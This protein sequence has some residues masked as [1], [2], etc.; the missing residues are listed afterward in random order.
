LDG[1]GAIVGL[2]RFCWRGAKEPATCRW[3]TL[4]ERDLMKFVYRSLALAISG[5]AFGA[6]AQLYSRP[7]DNSI[8]GYELEGYSVSPPPG[9]NWFEMQRDRQQVLFG[10]RL[11]SRTHSFVA[12]ATSGEVSEKFEKPEQFQDYVDKMRVAAV[13]PARYKIVEYHS[14]LDPSYPAQCVRYHS[15]TEDRGAPYSQGTALLLEHFG[16]A[17]LHPALSRLVVDVG[18]SERGRGA[19]INDELRAEGERFMRSLK[20][21]GK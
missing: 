16:V 7:V 11:D 14:A 3:E 13:D 6:G 19:E 1:A 20:F 2:R 21:T 8:P 5:I 15:K 18:Y 12:T 4:P 17:C 9:S 10:K